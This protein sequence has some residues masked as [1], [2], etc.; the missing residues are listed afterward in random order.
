[1]RTPWSTQ[2]THSGS[3]QSGHSRGRWTLRGRA[4][5][6]RPAPRLPT[7]LIHPRWRV[8]SLRLTRPTFTSWG[9]T[10]TK[11]MGGA[12]RIWRFHSVSGR[13]G[14]PWSLPRA[15]ILDTSFARATRTPSLARRSTKHSSRIRHGLPRYGWMTTK[16][17]SISQGQSPAYQTLATCQS[18]ASCANVSSASRSSGTWTRFCPRCLYQT[19]N[20]LGM[21]VPCEI[22]LE[23]SAWTKWDIGREAKQGYTFVMDKVEIRHSCTRRTTSCE[24]AKTSVS[25]R[26]R[27]NHPVMSFSKCVMD[28]REIKN[29]S[30][31]PK[32]TLMPMTR[33]MCRRLCTCDPCIVWKSP[34]SSQSI[35][36][37]SWHVTQART[38]NCGHGTRPSRFE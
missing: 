14:A 38:R 20:I 8:V 22:L 33:Q 4:G 25:I 35:N 37:I 30:F 21:L 28:K 2:P 9:P 19:R 6:P 13:A 16:S 1:M 36:S 15:P 23:D 29:L 26:G 24:Q 18:D 11:W 7:R 34:V 17:S 3:R 10:T 5:R 31:V 12:A 32:P 27:W